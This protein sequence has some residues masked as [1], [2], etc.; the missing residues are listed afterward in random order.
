[1]RTNILKKSN[2]FPGV[3]HD[4][5][6]WKCDGCGLCLDGDLNRPKNDDGRLW[7]GMQIETDSY[8]FCCIRCALD[9]MQVLH[10]TQINE[11]Q[12]DKCTSSGLGGPCNAE[13]CNGGCIS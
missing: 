3:Q 1:M 11:E 10:N 7:V 2:S 5:M 4:Y 12:A 13:N 8:H 9:R 6:Q